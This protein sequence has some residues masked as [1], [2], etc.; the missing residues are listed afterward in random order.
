MLSILSHMLLIFCLRIADVSLGTIRTILTTRGM[1]YWAAL[2]GFFEITIWITAVSKVLLSLSH[3]LY[4][5][6][7]AGG[8]ATGTLVGMQIVEW[9]AIGY[10]NIRAISP[11][12]GAAILAAVRGS[13]FGATL[14]KAEGRS[15][16]VG[17]VQVV[18]MRR[19]MKEVLRII[20]GADP[21]SFVTVED[22]PRVIG[23]YQKPAK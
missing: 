1:S 12:N 15:G 9:L 22:I 4:V 14:L 7:Y 19:F 2:C 21:H 5:V 10:V 8:F 17:L 18:V 20:A 16:S 11:Q 13:G 23:G 3:P 6:A